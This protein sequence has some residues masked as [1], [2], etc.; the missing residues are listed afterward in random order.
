MT[1]C[2]FI[3]STAINQIE[4]W[5]GQS[6]D[7]ETIERELGFASSL[8]MTTV[9]VYL[10]DLV[11]EAERTAFLD[12][13][14][15]FLTL[16]SRRGIKPLFVFFD[17]CWNAEAELGPQ[18]A[19]RPSVH[20]S[21]WV[22]SPCLSQRNWPEDF[23]R[24]EEYV[25]AVLERFGEDDRVWMWDLY[26]EPGN[27]SLGEKTRPLLMRVFEWAW[28]VRPRQ[29]L[30][31]GDWSKDLPLRDLLLENSDVISFH[32]YEPVEKLEAHIEELK[33]LGRP[34]VCT[35]WL[36]RTN[37]S[38]PVTH[39]PVFREHGVHC[40]NWGLVRGKTNTVWKWGAPEGAPEPNPGFHDLFWQDGSPYREE[41]AE[42]F[43]ALRG[44]E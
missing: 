27:E 2:N 17:D 25:K 40:I 30:T 12:R 37:D 3:P 9:R 23:R 21:G 5:Q 1:G 26:N 42:T 20:N 10:H 35:E 24:L 38:Q 6:W 13:I 8:G 11:F 14:D 22:K 19:P 4:M 15:E 39:L 44:G 7:P 43:R 31:A 36:A 34:L 29:P 16:A 33:P 28:E 18:P 32:N 41:E